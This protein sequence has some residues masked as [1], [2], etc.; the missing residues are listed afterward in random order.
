MR[1]ERSLRLAL[2]PD[3][4]WHLAL[5]SAGSFAGAWQ[6]ALT[7]HH[8]PLLI[9]LEYLCGPLTNTETGARLIVMVA[10]ALAP[11]VVFFWLRDRV[12]VTGAMVALVLL[13]FS[14]R[15]I[16]LSC[17]VRS[18]ALAWL[19]V[20][21]TLYWLDQRWLIA[22]GAAWCCAALSDY[23]VAL[24][25]PAI[26][27]YGWSRLPRTLWLKWVACTAVVLGI[28]GF[29]YWAQ[30]RHFVGNQ[31]ARE[32]AWIQGGLPEGDLMSFLPRAFLRQFVYFFGNVPLG[33]AALSIFLAALAWDR[34]WWSLAM[35]PF[36]VASLAAA[37]ELFPFGQT[38]HTSILA[39]SI[40]IPLSAAAEK[41][42]RRPVWAMAA[43]A[44][45]PV[46]WSAASPD[47]YDLDPLALD[48]VAHRAAAAYLPRFAPVLATDQVAFLL[49]YYSR[50]LS[51]LPPVIV[52]SGS[53]TFTGAT[54]LR[55]RVHEFRRAQS[56]PDEAPVWVAEGGFYP[57]IGPGMQVQASRHFGTLW[58]YQAL[59]GF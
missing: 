44:L 17:H 18:Y 35:L 54:D 55:Q 9:L 1:I 36:V 56:I 46:W 38:R 42:I 37:L 51:G 53:W 27:I 43:L 15:W 12:G 5:A 52:S 39:F 28:F 22:A 41:L 3:E 29:L 59:R 10:G 8:P 4:A 13:E 49:R 14:P 30:V 11:L 20:A 57:A 40:V 34:S 2:N 48:P 32:F 58:I 6:Q 47:R 23:S 21:L 26:T 31:T 24:M 33:V 7:V 45:V 19:F 16:S 25:S 50:G